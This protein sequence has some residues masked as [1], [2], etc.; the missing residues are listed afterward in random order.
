MLKEYINDIL[1]KNIIKELKLLAINSI[2]W[3]L[4]VENLMKRF[5]INYCKFNK[6][7]IMNYYLLFLAY[8]L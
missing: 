4:K 8:K 2:L 6:L 5:Y 3:V 1:K 7:T